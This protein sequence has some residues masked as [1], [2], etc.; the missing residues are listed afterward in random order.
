[1][2]AEYFICDLLQMDISFP[3]DTNQVSDNHT[4]GN[5]SPALGVSKHDTGATFPD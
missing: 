4:K 3:V 5:E 2:I 1:M